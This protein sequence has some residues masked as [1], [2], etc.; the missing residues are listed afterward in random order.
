M[1]VS[2]CNGSTTVFGTVS[3]GSSPC[4]TTQETRRLKFYIGFQPFFSNNIF[5]RNYYLL[6][7]L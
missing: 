5:G 4:E 6:L 3:Q 1:I 7:S 2:W